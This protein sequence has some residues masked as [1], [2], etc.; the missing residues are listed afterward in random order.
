[1]RVNLCRFSSRLQD[2]RSPNIELT[3][4]AAST[5]ATQTIRKKLG[6]SRENL[7]RLV[8]RFVSQS[9]PELNHQ[10]RSLPILFF[11]ISTP[12]GHN[13]EPSL[14]YQV[15]EFVRV[16][17]THGDRENCLFH[18]SPRLGVSVDEVGVQHERISRYPD[19]F[20]IALEYAVP[21]RYLPLEVFGL[22]TPSA[23]DLFFR[24]IGTKDVEDAAS[25]R[26]Q[27]LLDSSKKT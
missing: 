14:L 8:Q 22:V 25:I 10:F 9:L 24:R 19:V 4:A 11:R 3:S 6:L 26:G 18:D 21:V 7:R 23:K 2:T 5:G 27:M 20:T 12:C 17:A 1:M 16:E 15:L 13:A